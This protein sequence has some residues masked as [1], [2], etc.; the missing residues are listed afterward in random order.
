[1]DKL[2]HTYKHWDEITHPCS[3]FKGGSIKHLF[4]K[5]D[6]VHRIK[7]ICVSWDSWFSMIKLILLVLQTNY[8]GVLWWPISRLLMQWLIVLTSHQQSDYLSYGVN[9]SL[10]SINKAFSCLHHLCHQMI[11]NRSKQEDIKIHSKNESGIFAVRYSIN[12]S[13][14][15]YLVVKLRNHHSPCDDNFYL[16]VVEFSFN[17]LSNEECCQYR[18]LTPLTCVRY[19]HVKLILFW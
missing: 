6:P 19:R 4:I 7:S 10:P 8:D 9:G 2:L 12:I 3:N 5:G 14:E 11:Y 18:I 15:K 13:Y 1:M 16:D 17:L